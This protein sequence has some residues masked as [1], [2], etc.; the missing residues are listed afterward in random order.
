MGLQG[1]QEQMGLQGQQAL[2]IFGFSVR[3]KER[4]YHGYHNHIIDQIKHSEGNHWK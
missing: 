2:Y 4:A 3:R 1:Q